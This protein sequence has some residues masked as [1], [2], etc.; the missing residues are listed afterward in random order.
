MFCFFFKSFFFFHALHTTLFASWTTSLRNWH[1]PL[2]S[3]SQSCCKKHLVSVS[4]NPQ[5]PNTWLWWIWTCDWE[6]CFAQKVAG[7]RKERRSRGEKK[8]IKNSLQLSM[9]YIC[10]MHDIQTDGESLTLC[11]KHGA[12][13][14]FLCLLIYLAASP[15]IYA[16]MCHGNNVMCE[17]SF[18]GR[19]GESID[20][21]L[22]L[23]DF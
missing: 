11:C 15:S 22:R 13:L 21:D 4:L 3:S 17:C 1:E 16:Y 6:L 23:L 12:L 5:V 18:R 20:S 8:I 14:K 7:E 2:G 10:Q 9:R 19:R